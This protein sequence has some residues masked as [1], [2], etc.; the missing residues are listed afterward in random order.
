M[1]NKKILI[2]LGILLI[3]FLLVLFW[4]TNKTSENQETTRERKLVVPEAEFV[5]NTPKEIEWKLESD[6]GYNKAKVFLVQG[7]NWNDDDRAKIRS[8]L[9]GG[10]M[11][12][13]QFFKIYDT[14]DRYE[15]SRNIETVDE[16]E[17]GN[18]NETEIKEIM[19]NMMG[20]LREVNNE[21]KTEIVEVKY[22]QFLY[23]WWVSGTKEDHDI[24]ELRADFV[25]E[26]LPMTMFNGH[27]IIANYFTN[28]KLAKI[29]GQVPFEKT[30]KSEEKELLSLEDIK[31][32][33]PENAKI[34]SIDGGQEYEL[35]EEDVLVEKVTIYD[36]Q[37]KYIY[38]F[39]SKTVW[40]FYFLNANSQLTTGPA[41]VIL[42]IP[43]TKE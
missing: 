32:I 16:I 34:W 2:I 11:P 13:G 42:I 19:G 1:T 9:V 30:I 39:K 20:Q 23:P 3:V 36:Y 40:P 5:M 12:V 43:A 33:K 10:A 21:I 26:S 4:P 25:F 22:K 24:L 17:E 38:G 18:M 27:P 29:Q 14:A 15:F 31:K 37:L 7:K 28:G 6:K 35:A 41:K 8:V